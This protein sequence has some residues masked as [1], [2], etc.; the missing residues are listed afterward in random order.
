[1]AF[2]RGFAVALALVSTTAVFGAA[3]ASAAQPPPPPPPPA[4]GGTG[5]IGEAQGVIDGQP[6]TIAELAACD[7]SGTRFAS[8]PG[9]QS[10]DIVRYGW[11]RSTCSRDWWGTTSVQVNGTL[12]RLDALR[13]WGGPTIHVSGFS[14][15]C[16]AGWWGTWSNFQVSGV[17]GVRI[18]ARV[19]PNYT[20][21]VRGSGMPGSTPIAKVVVNEVDRSVP[22]TLK[23]N[24]L[25]ITLF[26]SG[27]SIHSGDFVVGSVSCSR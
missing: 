8:T 13:R 14:V 20:V 6:V 16:Q 2:R 19:P 10:G 4:S 18:P 22:G 27:P 11:G 3:P 21:W 1:M 9:A 12:F 24:L 15:A 7:T 23:I 17:F 26:P 5:S 25:H